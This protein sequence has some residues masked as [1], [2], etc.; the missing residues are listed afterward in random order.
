MK[1][2]AKKQTGGEDPK[3]TKAKQDSTKAANLLKAVVK[4]KLSVK[5]YGPGLLL[6]E[7]NKPAQVRKE[8]GIKKT[9]GATKSKK[10]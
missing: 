1:R 10:K 7:L 5:D 6:K 8:L 3:L 4:R 9:G 2:L